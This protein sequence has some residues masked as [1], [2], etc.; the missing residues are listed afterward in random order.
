MYVSLEG[1]AAEP[2]RNQNQPA[3]SDLSRAQEFLHEF[4]PKLQRSLFPER[5]ELSQQQ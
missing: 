1:S 2:R 5:E 3:E 4:L